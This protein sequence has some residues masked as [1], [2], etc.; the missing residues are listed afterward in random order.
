M[1]TPVYDVFQSLHDSL[2]VTEQADCRFGRPKV[3]EALPE[4]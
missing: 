3:N 2:V 4:I 1:T